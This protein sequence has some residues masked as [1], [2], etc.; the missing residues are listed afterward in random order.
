MELDTG[1]TAWMLIS[2]S[3]V[4]LMT[5][6]LAFFYGGMTRSK[7]VLNMMMM[8]FGAMGVIGVVYVLMLGSIGSMMARESIGAIGVAKGR[9]PVKPRKRRH[10]PLVA[11]LAGP[12]HDRVPEAL[13][14]EVVQRPQRRLHRVGDPLLVAADRLDVDEV[15][16]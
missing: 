11:A 7:S 2:A 3:L 5:P 13:H 14:V 9:R 15:L 12:G 16:G 10:H 8:S 4:L 6:G 1:T